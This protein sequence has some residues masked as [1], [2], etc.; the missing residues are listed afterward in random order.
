MLKSYIAVCFY[1]FLYRYC[2]F[3]QYYVWNIKNCH[4]LLEKI[5][6]KRPLYISGKKTL[7]HVI[8]KSFLENL[9]LFGQIKSQRDSGKQRVPYVASLSKWMAKQDLRAI[10]KDKS[11]YRLQRKRN[12]R[13]SWYPTFW[14]DRRQTRRKRNFLF[15]VGLSKFV[16]SLSLL[17]HVLSAIHTSSWV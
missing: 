3:S 10:K 8:R 14:R 1:G 9:L 16:I 11:Y 17:I 4:A 6:T 12:C 7:G 5:E 15:F 13:E 2:I